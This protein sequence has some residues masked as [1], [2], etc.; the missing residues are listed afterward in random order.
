M[1]AQQNAALTGCNHAF[2]DQLVHGLRCRGQKQID[3]RSLLNL[4]GQHAGG[5]EV[6]AKLDLGV[7]LLERALQRL[8]G[9][10]KARRDGDGEL[11]VLRRVAARQQ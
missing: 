1:V 9:S 11:H 8:D 3:G 4:P 2:G 6:V 5:T 7:L 10:R